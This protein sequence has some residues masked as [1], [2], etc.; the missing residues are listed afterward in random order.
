MDF[1]Q[2][3]GQFDAAS[4][5]PC[6]EIDPTVPFHYLISVMEPVTQYLRP[7][8]INSTRI[9]HS[10]QVDDLTHPKKLNIRNIQIRQRIM[11]QSLSGVHLTLTRPIGLPPHTPVAQKIADPR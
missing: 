3:W 1:R 7:F 5:A 4:L 11:F 10:S 9:N 6:P 2:C 8:L